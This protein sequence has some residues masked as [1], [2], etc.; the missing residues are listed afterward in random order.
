MEK[1]IFLWSDKKSAGTGCAED[2]FQPYIETYLLETTEALGAVIVLPGGGY[3]H[4]AAHEGGPIAEKF[5]AD[6]YLKY[7]E[8]MRTH[9][10]LYNSIQ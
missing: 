9:T 10:R 4:R 6:D 7:Y 1:K 8:L 2:D 3:S 5:N